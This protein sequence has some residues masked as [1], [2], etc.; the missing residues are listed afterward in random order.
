MDYSHSNLGGK[1]AFSL[2]YPRNCPGARK[3]RVHGAWRF[4][5]RV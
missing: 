5:C 2:M 4:A 3:A 1:D